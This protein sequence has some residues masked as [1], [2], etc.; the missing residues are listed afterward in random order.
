MTE[1]IIWLTIC[2]YHEAR[3]EPFAGQVAVGHVVL[4]RVRETDHS[5][6]D[7]VLKPWQFSWANGD[8]RPPIKDYEAFESCYSAAKAC[9]AERMDGKDLF[10]ANHYFADY[11][12]A[13]EWSAKMKLITKIGKHNF[14][15]G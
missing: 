5:V 6:K 11:I 2:I 13:P 1:Q 12:P 4:N 3:G 8:A 9:R 10:G 7:V 14:F 15:K